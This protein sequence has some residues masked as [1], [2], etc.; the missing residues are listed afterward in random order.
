[1]RRKKDLI[2]LRKHA[3]YFPS[4]KIALALGLA[5]PTYVGDHARSACETVFL[6]NIKSKYTSS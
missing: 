1:M 6:R 4:E 5:P 2:F 3:V